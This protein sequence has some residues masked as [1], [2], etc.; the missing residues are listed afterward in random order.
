MLWYCAKIKENIWTL[1]PL[2]VNRSCAP[3]DI[4]AS[5]KIRVESQ[6]LSALCSIRL[7]LSRTAPHFKFSS[8]QLKSQKNL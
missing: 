4:C 5:A 2:S 6:I 1:C 8:I 3:A 7:T